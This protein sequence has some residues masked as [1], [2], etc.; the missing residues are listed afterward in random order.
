MCILYRYIAINHSLGSVLLQTQNYF[1]ASNLVVYKK[2][3][4]YYRIQVDYR[5]DDHQACLLKLCYYNIIYIYI[6]IICIIYHYL[7]ILET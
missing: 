7:S 5:W 2:N 3:N 1:I 6:Y 4:I